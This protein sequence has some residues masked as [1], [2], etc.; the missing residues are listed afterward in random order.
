M[1]RDFLGHGLFNSDG[2]QWLWQRKNASLQFTSRSLRGSVVQAEV[3][4]RLIPLLRRAA[5]SGEVVD[6]QDVLER[7]AFD[8]IC[9]VAFGH[10]PC[11]LAD[12]GVVDE[13]RSEFMRAFGEA[14]DLVVGRF[15]DPVEV[16]WKVKKWLNVGT[17][18]M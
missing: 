14:Q 9:K 8:T 6:L 17:I 2:E 7:F 12:G 13:A 1:L 5:T 16:S 4:D 3:A 15:L 11:C 18:S 10:D